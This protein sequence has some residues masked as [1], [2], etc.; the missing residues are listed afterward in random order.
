MWL[1]IRWVFL[2]LRYEDFD[3]SAKET[4]AEMTR[5]PFPC[6]LFLLRVEEFV[7]YKQEN[8]DTEVETEQLFRLW[9]I[10]TVVS[11]ARLP[12]SAQQ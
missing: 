5:I 6:M 2:D 4:N 8:L 12:K 10:V 7:A 9:V 11:R 1:R 3:A